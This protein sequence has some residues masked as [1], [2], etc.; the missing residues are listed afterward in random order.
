MQVLK[1]RVECILGIESLGEDL[2]AKRIDLTAKLIAYPAPTYLIKAPD[3]FM[4]EAGIFD[5]NVAIVNQAIKP[6]HD[7]DV[8]KGSLR[9]GKLGIR[10]IRTALINVSRPPERQNFVSIDDRSGDLFC[11]DALA[12]GLVPY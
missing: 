11:R 4:V 10:S 8:T 2:R 12:H 3:T 7:V 1:T 9:I 5:G 6:K